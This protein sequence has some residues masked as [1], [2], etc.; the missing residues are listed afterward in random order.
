M[1]L[2]VRP[3]LT[4]KILCSSKKFT[5]LKYCLSVN[6]TTL[7]FAINLRLRCNVFSQN[8]KLVMTI[9]KRIKHEEI[10][11]KGINVR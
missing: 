8:I 7:A 11:I 2:N 6:D 5:A 10:T 9:D 1:Q 3:I 4:L